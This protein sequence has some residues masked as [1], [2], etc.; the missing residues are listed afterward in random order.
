MCVCFLQMRVKVEDGGD[1]PRSATTVLTINI[2][3]NLNSPIFDS[4]SDCSSE[5]SEN[6]NPAEVIGSVFATD[7]D[8]R[9][10]VDFFT[11]DPAAVLHFM[12]KS[13]T[14]S[15]GNLSDSFFPILKAV[16]CTCF[17]LRTHMVR[18]QDILNLL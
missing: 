6:Q 1:P 16:T 9:V 5:L 3:Y 17:N 18:S 10:S 8:T 15:G 7:S 12:G 4:I 13:C 14:I 2:N 11:F